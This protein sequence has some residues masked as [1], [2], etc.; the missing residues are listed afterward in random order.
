[1]LRCLPIAEIEAAIG[2]GLRYLGRFAIAPFSCF[3]IGYSER[4]VWTERR[5]AGLTAQAVAVKKV[6]YMVAPRADT[7]IS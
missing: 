2:E 5:N 4:S 7:F 1:M 3:C 6:A